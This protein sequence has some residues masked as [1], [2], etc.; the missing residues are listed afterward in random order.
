MEATFT[1][2]TETEITLQTVTEIMDGTRS[3]F[4]RWWAGTEAAL[5][6]THLDKLCEIAAAKHLSWGFTENFKGL[7][8]LAWMDG[9]NMAT[10]AATAMLKR[11]NE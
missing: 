11:A 3:E 5:Y 10:R 9:A 2:E 1:E 8:F 4:E 6:R 7:A